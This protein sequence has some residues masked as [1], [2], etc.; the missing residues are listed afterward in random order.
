MR[1]SRLFFWPKLKQ[2]VITWVQGCD[3]CCRSN[4]AGGL[5]PGLLQPLPIP[6]QAWT[7][8]SMDFIEGLP[9]SQGKN[10][11]LVVV[12]RFTKYGHFIPLSH[13]FT[14]QSVAKAF[15]DQ[16]YK[17]HGQPLSIVTDR[18]KVFTSNFWK[19]LF[20]MMGTSLDMTSAYHPQSDGQT[21]RLNQCLENY[22]RCMVHQNPKL[23]LQWLPLA[24]L[25]YNTN[26]HS[27]LKAT[28]FETLYGYPPPLH[29]VQTYLP[30]SDTEAKDFMQQRTQRLQE[31][32]ENLQQAQHRMKFYADKK[33][34]EREF[35]VGDMVY[36]KL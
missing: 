21:E 5:Y 15:L 31:L 19:E 23:W 1:I 17:L 29:S 25:W 24:E 10:V 4:A 9:K 35:E 13:P 6:D 30:S 2:D 12:D 27:S 11:I 14:A 8:I 32:K 34:V 36:L 26:Y 33:R 16:V 3:V 20:K 7:H 28:P 22:L 18:D